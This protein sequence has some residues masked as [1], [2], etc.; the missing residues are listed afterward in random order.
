MIATGKPVTEILFT[1]ADL[2]LQV[3][4]IL[5]SGVCPVLEGT[6]LYVSC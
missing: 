4:M 2:P 5:S 6:L 1:F 3:T